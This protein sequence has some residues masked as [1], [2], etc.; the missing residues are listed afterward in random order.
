MIIQAGMNIKIR[1]KEERDVFIEVAHKE[2]H[3]G[4]D[5]TDPAR[6][7]NYPLS[8]SVGYRRDDVYPKDLSWDSVDYSGGLAT[9]IVE[10][11][12]LFR[13][14]LISKRLK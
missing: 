14:Q 3:L 6:I 7:D 5:G 12:H 2:G 8:V 13:N 10:A 1:T 4:R 11:S 9:N